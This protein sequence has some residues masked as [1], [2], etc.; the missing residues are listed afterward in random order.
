MSAKKPEPEYYFIHKYLT[1]FPENVTNDTQSDFIKFGNHY[2]L[3][4]LKNELDWD[5]NT[6]ICYTIFSTGHRINLNELTGPLD[7]ENYNEYV[8]QLNA[9]EELLVI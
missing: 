5:G 1:Q 4:Y 8:K 6:G 3:R 7:R 9:E 2:D